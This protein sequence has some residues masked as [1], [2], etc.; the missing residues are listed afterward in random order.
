VLVGVDFDNTIVCYD[1]LFH[2]IA[3]EQGL[4]PDAVP[5]TKRAVRDHLRAVGR[6]ADWTALQGLVYGPR[7]REAEPFPGVHG[8]FVGCRERGV[9]V[10][11][12][13]HKTRQPFLGPAHDLHEAAHDWL[14]AQGFYGPSR[15]G[16][17]PAS[18]H[19]EL[20]RAGKLEQIVRAGCSHFI[21]DLPEFLGDPTFPASV[22][23]ILFQ[24]AGEIAP[25]SRWYHATSWPEIEDLLQCRTRQTA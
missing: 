15:V 10:R 21:D 12:I 25:D 16:L 5:A 23:R 7:M 6:E 18:V 24:P 9:P 4:I 17:S 22:T 14:A 20:T 2:R 19:F 3:V 11:I 1:G 8:F 13:S